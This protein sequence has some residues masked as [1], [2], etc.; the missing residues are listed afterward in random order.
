MTLNRK[1]GLPRTW[2]NQVLANI[3]PLF[4]GEVANVSG[5]QDEDKEGGSYRE[6][7]TSAKSYT[8]TNFEGKRGS[9]GRE[10]E[11][12]L[13][14]GRKLPPELEGRF[15]VVFNHTTLEHVFDFFTAFENLCRLSRDVVIVV[16]PFVQVSHDTPSYEDFWRFTPTGMRRLFE[17]N[18]LRMIFEATSRDENASVYL[19]MAGSRQPEEWFAKLPR[20]QPIYFA[21]GWLGKNWKEK[22]K[23]L[24]ARAKMGR[25]GLLANPVL[26]KRLIPAAVR[27]W[28]EQK[29]EN[30]RQARRQET[31]RLEIVLYHSVTDTVDEFRVTGHT[32][33]RDE[34]VAQISYLREHFTLVRVK[35]I[36]ELFSGEN[37][38]K[39]P[40]A[41]VC[42]DDGYRDNIE[43]AYPVLEE[44]GI[45]AT[46]FLTPSVVGNQ[47]LLWRDRIR[48]IKLKGC[49]DHFLGFLTHDKYVHKYN[50]EML[51]FLSFDLWSKDPA[52]ITDMSIAGHI[53]DFFDEMGWDPAEVAARYDLFMDEE[54]VRPYDLLDYGNHTWSHPMMTLLN[55][56]GQK[57]EIVSCH[58]YLTGKGLEPVGLGLPFTPYDEN[59]VKICRELD[60]PMLFTVAKGLAGM[61]PLPAQ[62]PE[63]KPLK[64]IRS[65]APPTASELAGIL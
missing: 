18:G 21:G 14:L 23:S 20:Y 26:I 7:F 54:Q 2:S 3:A 43:T 12:F 62:P 39:G 8:L 35:D 46:L 58:E 42:F 45:P 19:L 4:E 64:L 44:M 11:I 49:V 63:K 5:W 25:E 53:Q 59:T 16:V 61:N 29:I 37:A 38:G 34:F 60:Y 9:T 33:T 22:A 36:P 28:R 10:G 13:D 31:N 41:A 47:D 65:L 40:F 56:E 48:Y 32:V 27:R 24:V 52:A 6:Y 15:D 1:F 30:I 55:Y 50:F 51:D 57:R 17:Q